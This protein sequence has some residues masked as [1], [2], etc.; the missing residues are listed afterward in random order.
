MESACHTPRR[1]FTFSAHLSLGGALLFS[2]LLHIA[3]VLGVNLGVQRAKYHAEKEPF[4]PT[5][6][7]ARVEISFADHEDSTAD[8]QQ[9]DSAPTAPTRAPEAPQPAPDD[10]VPSEEPAVLGVPAWTGPLPPTGDVPLPERLIHIPEAPDAPLPKSAPATETATPSL[11]APYQAHVNTFS[12]NLNCIVR[13]PRSARAR[14]QEGTVI[15]LMRIDAGG[16]DILDVKL[17]VP[18]PVEAFNREALRAARKLRTRT[19]EAAAQAT[20][21]LVRVPVTFK[22]TD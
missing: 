14:N 9:Q 20:D 6:D 17:D 15:L 5:L 1:P 19:R 2:V 3:L 12:T 10:A 7:L 18:S 21:I 22:L 8:V 11:A 16:K 4:L 13:Y